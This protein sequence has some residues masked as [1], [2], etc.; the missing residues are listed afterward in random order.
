MGGGSALGS[1]DHLPPTDPRRARAGY[2][3]GMSELGHSYDGGL[4]G[5][6]VIGGGRGSMHAPPPGRSRSMAVP[7]YG[8]HSDTE[9]FVPSHAHQQQYQQHPM[10]GGANSYYGSASAMTDMSGGAMGG[11]GYG[12]NPSSYGAGGG[13]MPLQHSFDGGMMGGGAGGG[14]APVDQVYEN[15]RA[16][17]DERRAQAPPPPPRNVNFEDEMPTRNSRGGGGVLR[18]RTF[19]SDIESVTSAFSSHSAPHNRPRRPG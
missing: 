3:S 19:D 2:R 17:P 11:R 4:N 15:T 1:R 5:G 18:G 7:G 16:Y 8:G 14:H 6:G 9:V 13:G 10:G 12:G